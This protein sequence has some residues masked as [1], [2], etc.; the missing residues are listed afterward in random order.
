MEAGEAAV[1]ATSGVPGCD[2]PGKRP[3]TMRPG[4]PRYAVGGYCARA[5]AVVLVAPHRLVIAPFLLADTNLTW[6]GIGLLVAGLALLTST[7]LPTP[8]VIGL[9]A[10]LAAGLLIL[11]TAAGLVME[12]R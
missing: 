11:L 3:D 5:G 4:A 12:E 2:P 1:G 7:A 10:Q 6:W 9:T 8:R